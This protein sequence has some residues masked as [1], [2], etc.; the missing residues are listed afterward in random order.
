MAGTSH[1]QRDPATVGMTAQQSGDMATAL[2][3]GCRRVL[4]VL[5]AVPCP[6]TG[7]GALLYE[8]LA[9][10]SER[11]SVHAVVPSIPH[12]KA[13]E[14]L[15]VQ[16]PALQNVRWSFLSPAPQ[17][18]VAGK[19]VR[20]ASRL[21]GEVYRFATAANQR[22]LEELQACLSPATQ[23][24]VSSSAVASYRDIRML[25]SARVYMMD[26]DPQIVWYDGPSI[27]RRLATA[28]DRTKVDRLCRS[29][30]ANAG[31]V[32]TI[33]SKDVPA[34]NEM[35]SRTDVVHVPPVMRPRWINRSSA[36]R[37]QVLITTNFSYPPNVRSL[38]WFLRECWPLV[39]A[40]ARLLITGRD[41]GGKLAHLCGR[42]ARV[43]YAGCVS[44][45]A[46]DAIYSESALAVNP[47]LIG[48]GF[49]IKL[50]DAIARG[51]PVVSTA[52]S[53]RLGAAI[54]SSDDPKVLASLINE[55]LEPGGV[56][57][58]DYSHFYEAATRAWETFLFGPDAN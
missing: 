57:S 20:F 8:L 38:E 15:L 23:L 28:I 32:G 21:P 5:P 48:S 19:V 16:D 12:L 2:Q 1:T 22:R 11:N 33:S 58:F 6:T 55:R 17:S 24:V 35:G 7:G 4:C 34:L 51:V 30:L 47:T 31:R 56:A 41:E 3:E 27:K 53:N 37:G 13:E 46:L 49:Q 45:S 43:T 9:H 25:S 26:V 10:L 42:H 52:F 39:S 50:L 54:A 29:V 36:R 14:K 44:A 18:P 40:H